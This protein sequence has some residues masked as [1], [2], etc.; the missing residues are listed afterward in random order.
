MNLFSLFRRLQKAR[1]YRS[2]IQRWEAACRRSWAIL[3]SGPP[4]LERFERWEKTHERL[5]RL[6]DKKLHAK[7]TP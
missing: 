1:D 3:A 7:S 6:A 2:W 5:M 4:T